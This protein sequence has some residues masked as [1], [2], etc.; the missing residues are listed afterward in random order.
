MLSGAVQAV[1]KRYPELQI[2]EDGESLII[3]SDSALLTLAASPDQKE[4]GSR[5]ER[6]FL[7][8]AAVEPDVER[9]TLCVDMLNGALSTATSNTQLL[10]THPYNPSGTATV[11]PK[12]SVSDTIRDARYRYSGLS[13]TCH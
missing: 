13:G 2:T 10:S 7:F 4:L 12:F 6:L 9:A 11:E 8:A 1:G 3:G 5:L